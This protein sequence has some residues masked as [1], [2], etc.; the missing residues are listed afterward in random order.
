MVRQNPGHPAVSISERLRTG[1]ATTLMGLAARPL[2]PQIKDGVV[3]ESLYYTG[4][5]VWMSSKTRVQAIT[6]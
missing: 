1:Q 4:G 3:L 5:F 6:F 2:S